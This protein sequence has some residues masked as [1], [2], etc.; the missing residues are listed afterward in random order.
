MLNI[1]Y[2]PPTRQRQ[3][4]DALS[5]ITHSYDLVILICSRNFETGIFSTHNVYLGTKSVQI[6]KKERFIATLYVVASKR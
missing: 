6:T 4:T 5:W 3:R 2:P 1:R